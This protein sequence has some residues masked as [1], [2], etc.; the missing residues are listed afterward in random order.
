MGIESDHEVVRRGGSGTRATRCAHRGRGCGTSCQSAA[1]IKCCADRPDSAQQAPRHSS[2]HLCCRPHRSVC[3]HRAFHGQYGTYSCDRDR[4]LTSRSSC[5][6]RA[7]DWAV[8]AAPDQAQSRSTLYHFHTTVKA[9]NL[10]GAPCGR[11]PPR[12]PRCPYTPADARSRSSTPV[13]PARLSPP[14]SENLLAYP[15]R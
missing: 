10:P 6:I 5:W 2:S 11:P 14:L 3:V 4:I 15:S 1:A 12:A 13:F 8:W 9:T 7:G